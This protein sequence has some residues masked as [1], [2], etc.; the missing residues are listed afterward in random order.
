METG[1]IHSGWMRRLLRWVAEHRA[2]QGAIRQLCRM[3]GW[4]LR[5]MGIDRGR[6]PEIVDGLLARQ[7]ALA[8]ESLSATETGQ[9]AGVLDEA[10]VSEAP[11]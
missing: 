2:R 11:V 1:K 10:T 3:P 7:R 5:D 6:I 9:A 8:A 4:R